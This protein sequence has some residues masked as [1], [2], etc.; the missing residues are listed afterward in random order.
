MLRRFLTGIALASCIQPLI[1][2][3]AG[4]TLASR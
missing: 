2:T 4:P 3:E 1:A